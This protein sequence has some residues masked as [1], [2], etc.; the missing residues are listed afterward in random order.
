MSRAPSGTRIEVTADIFSKVEDEIKKVIHPDDIDMM[1]D[2]IG[3][4][5]VPYTLAFGDN[6]SVGGYDGEIFIS[7]KTKRKYPTQKYMAMLRKHLRRNFQTC[8]FFFQ[9]A[10][11]VNQILNI[12]I[13]DPIDVKVSDMTKKII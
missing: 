13:A 12:G 4:N 9:P 8:Y 7:L 3:V 6:T 1:I 2:N 11:M 5:P 10:D